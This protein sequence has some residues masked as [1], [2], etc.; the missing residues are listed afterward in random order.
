MRWWSYVSLRGAILLIRRSKT[1]LQGQ[2]SNAEM[3]E[4]IKSNVR[5]NLNT[6]N[7]TFF[8][9]LSSAIEIVVRDATCYADKSQIEL[10]S[11]WCIRG[12][13]FML[14]VKVKVYMFHASSLLN[15]FL[16]I[17][18]RVL[19]T[20]Q[21]VTVNIRDWENMVIIC[22]NQKMIL[23]D[24][25]TVLVWNVKWI[26]SHWWQLWGKFD[27]MENVSCDWRMRYLQD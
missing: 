17:F 20:T 5:M 27:T 8:G 10:D 6:W 23:I 15:S 21:N 2:H 3:S 25:A 16:G 1:D 26:V 11:D 24:D 22:D 14:L 12:W 13:N 19:R 18:P 4:R 7:E 9:Y